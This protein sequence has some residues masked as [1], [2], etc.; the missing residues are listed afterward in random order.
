MVALCIEELAVH[1][2]GRVDGITQHLKDGRT[3]FWI[4]VPFNHVVGLADV[5]IVYEPLLRRAR[6]KREIRVVQRVERI[7]APLELIAHEL[8]LPIPRQTIVVV[9]D[10]LELRR[11]FRES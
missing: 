2:I 11:Q 5:L 7:A 6:L 3:L 9:E 1:L 8:W 10:K 4:D